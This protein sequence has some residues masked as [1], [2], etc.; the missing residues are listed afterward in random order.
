MSVLISGSIAYDTILSFDGRF[1]DSLHAEAIAH[2]NLTFPASAMRR[3]FGGCAA[4]VAYALKCLGGK[5]L[6]WSAMGKDAA[7]YMKH[8]EAL[9]IS[10]FGLKVLDDSWMPQAFITTDAS[11][12]QLTTFH[13]GAM[14]RTQE[15]PFPEIDTA[16]G[17]DGRVRTGAQALAELEDLGPVTLAMLSPGG[18]IAM[19]CHAEICV[20][21]GIPY[22]FDVGQAAPLFSGEELRRFIERAYAVAF[23]DYEAEL[24]ERASGLSPEAIAKPGKIVFHTHGARGSSVWLAN[25]QA[26]VAVPAA[27]VPGGAARDPVGA[28]DAYRGGLLFGLTSGLGPVVSARIASIMGAIKVS[29]S[30]VQNYVTTLADVRRTYASLWGEAPF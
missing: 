30:G 29:A 22:I 18:K 16:T 14:D 11:G 17:A 9:G 12:N 19:G 3:E 28:G 5:P 21:R 1:A 23:S 4:N 24:I 15:V 25:A 10:T 6:L 27:P 7:P 20:E 8:L 2:L 26:P 13:G